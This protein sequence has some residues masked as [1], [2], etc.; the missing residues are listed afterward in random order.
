MRAFFAK[1]ANFLW[2]IAAA[3]IAGSAVFCLVGQ[4]AGLDAVESA[5]LGAIIGGVA[6]TAFAT[7]AAAE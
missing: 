3:T 2:V 4:L 7:A 6:A 5:Q 1:F